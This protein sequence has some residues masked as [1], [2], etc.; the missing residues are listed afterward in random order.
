MRYENTVKVMPEVY[1]NLKYSCK[2]KKPNDD[3]FDRVSV[4]VAIFLRI[5]CILDKFTERVF[6]IDDGWINSKSI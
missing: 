6:K 2:R 3:I 1:R 4:S 5:E